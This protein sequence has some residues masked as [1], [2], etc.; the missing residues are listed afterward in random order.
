MNNLEVEFFV[1]Q[2]LNTNLLQPK[3]S[4]RFLIYEF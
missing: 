1:M 4:I 2:H 3:H